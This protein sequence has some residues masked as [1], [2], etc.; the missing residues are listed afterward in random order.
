MLY[1][2][3]T[4]DGTISHLNPAAL[5]LIGQ[6]EQVVRGKRFS[7]VFRFFSEQSGE[8]V[9]DPIR[10]VVEGGVQSR[11]SSGVMLDAGEGRFIPVLG[12][13]SI[14]RHKDNSVFGVVVVFR[15][16][17]ELRTRQR[18]RIT[19]YNVCYTKLLRGDLERRVQRFVIHHERRGV[20]HFVR[21]DGF[22]VHTIDDVFLRLEF[23]Q[24]RAVVLTEFGP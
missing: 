1:E 22:L 19:S 8:P 3:I 17:T 15:D 12:S 21:A 16:Q 5:R 24:R 11:L 7:E 20:V 23:H 10:Q 14:L 6:G 18:I 13:A 2:V 4:A 9:E